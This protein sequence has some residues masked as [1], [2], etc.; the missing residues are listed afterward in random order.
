M[1][2]GNDIYSLLQ[3]QRQRRQ[4]EEQQQRQLLQEQEHL[5]RLT[6]GIL[7]RVSLSGNDALS[8]QHDPVYDGDAL[9]M[10]RQRK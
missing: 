1:N 2:N 8:A 7:S 10:E 6:R 9:L 3:Q 5:Q 4:E